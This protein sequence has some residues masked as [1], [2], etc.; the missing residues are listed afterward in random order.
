[1]QAEGASDAGIVAMRDFCWSTS[2][3]VDVALRCTDDP[4]LPAD[5]ALVAFSVRRAEA[6]SAACPCQPPCSFFMFSLIESSSCFNA[7]SLA[8][9]VWPAERMLLMST[10]AITD[11]ICADGIESKSVN[12]PPPPLAKPCI[13]DHSSGTVHGASLLPAHIAD[14]VQADEKIEDL[15]LCAQVA[16][17]TACTRARVKFV[18][19][20]GSMV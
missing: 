14:A 17:A 11:L 1:M 3:A 16:A 8:A 20:N 10:P 2:S 18:G 12:A 6:A 19:V 5:S 15:T 4:S 9:P 13:S 7:A